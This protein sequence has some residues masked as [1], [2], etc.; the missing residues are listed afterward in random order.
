MNI[1]LSAGGPHGMA[2]GPVMLSGAYDL[3]YPFMSSAR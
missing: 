2:E 1:S 3:D